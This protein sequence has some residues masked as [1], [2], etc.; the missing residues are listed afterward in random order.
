MKNLIEEIS[1]KFVDNVEPI[2]E[3]EPAAKLEKKPR[4]YL[5]QRDKGRKTKS[6]CNNCKVPICSDHSINICKICY[7][8]NYF[9]EL[10]YT[11]IRHLGPLKG[12][13]WEWTLDLTF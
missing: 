11:T 2:H 10:L 1:D 6:V 13:L 8:K 5:C 3:I 12:R 4:C 9:N 7:E